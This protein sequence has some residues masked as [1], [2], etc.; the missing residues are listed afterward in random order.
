MKNIT[1]SFRLYLDNE[2]FNRKLA[3]YARV[4][5]TTEWKFVKDVFLTVKGEMMVDMF[6]ERFTSLSEKD[7]DI[8]QQ[9]YYQIN[10][11]LDFLSEPKQWVK[12]KTL[13]HSKRTSKFHLFKL[14]INS[15]ASPY[16]FI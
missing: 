15:L 16:Y 11:L 8:K 14:W 7:K 13:T 5:D 2:D 6:S 4:I 10:Q 12:K 1:N 9:T 3:E